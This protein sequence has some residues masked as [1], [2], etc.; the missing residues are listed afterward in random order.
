MKILIVCLLSLFSFSCSYNDPW[1]EFKTDLREYTIDNLHVVVGV[2]KWKD[3]KFIVQS[4]DGNE[5]TIDKEVPVYESAL[6]LDSFKRVT[7]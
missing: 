2:G 6:T 5:W 4:Y 3:N 7:K 1:H